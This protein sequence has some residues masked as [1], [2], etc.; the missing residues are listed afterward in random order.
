V[1]EI[2]SQVPA[3][4]RDLLQSRLTA[5]AHHHRRRRSPA[6][7]CGLVPH[8]RGRSTHRVDDI[9]PAEVQEPRP[10]AACDLFI[11]DPANAYRTLEVRAEAEMTPDP[12]KSTV[13]AFARAYGMDEAALLTVDED[14]CTFIFPPRRVVATPRS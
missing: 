9:G 11:I 4:H 3:G 7:D 13:R 5:T 10:Q 6:V 8:R 12:D 14:R 1:S 2:L